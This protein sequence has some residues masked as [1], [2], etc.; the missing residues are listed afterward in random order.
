MAEIDR[1]RFTQ[2]GDPIPEMWPKPRW[3]VDNLIQDRASGDTGKIIE[4]IVHANDICYLV[5]S[6]NKKTRFRKR[7]VKTWYQSYQ[8]GFGPDN[9]YESASRLIPFTPDPLTIDEIP[10]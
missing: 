8:G 9:W 6:F 10:L 5:E 3:K 1:S 4:V 7:S 2:W